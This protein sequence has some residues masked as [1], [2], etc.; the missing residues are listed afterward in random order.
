MKYFSMILGAMVLCGGAAFGQAGGCENAQDTVSMQ[1][2]LQ[3]EYK[4]ADGALNAAYKAAM[5]HMQSIDADLPK[6]D[7]GAAAALKSAQRAWIAVRDG[8][9]KAEGYTWF[10]GSGRSILVQSCLVRQTQLRTD[11]LAALAGYE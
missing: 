6:A 10:G 8:T 9:C 7:Q 3:Q 1:A 5:A 11:D 2:C 4:V